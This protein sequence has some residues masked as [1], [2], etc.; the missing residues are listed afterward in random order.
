NQL[1]VEVKLFSAETGQEIDSFYPPIDPS[2][3]Y[4]TLIKHQAKSSFRYL[5][6]ISISSSPPYGGSWIDNIKWR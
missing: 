1:S 2:N 5:R 6:V 3:P 4:S